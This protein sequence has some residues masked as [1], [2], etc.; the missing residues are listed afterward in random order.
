MLEDAVTMY[1]AKVMILIDLTAMQTEAA[2]LEAETRS[3]KVQSCKQEMGTPVCP[4]LHAQE[5]AHQ[6]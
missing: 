1:T 2:G 3:C 5:I 4:W 6:C